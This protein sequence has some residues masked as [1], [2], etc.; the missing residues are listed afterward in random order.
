[1]GTY[2]FS[3][4]GQGADLEELA[5]SLFRGARIAT[6]GVGV[7]DRFDLQR[8]PGGY[9]LRQA[10]RT[11]CGASDLTGAFR[12]M[13]WALTEACLAHLDAY[14]QFHAGAVVCRGGA[15]LLP[16]SPEAGKTSLALALYAAGATVWTDEVALL[17]PH[18]LVAVPFPRDLVVRRGT[19]RALV[20]ALPAPAA[21]WQCTAEHSYL[22]P[23]DLRSR[24]RAQA[25]VVRL[26]FP[27]LAP[28]RCP[29]SRRLGPAEAARRL[30]DQALNGQHWHGAHI[31]ALAR[32]VARCPATEV[33]FSDCRTAARALLARW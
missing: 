3:L 8:G 33:T 26:V 16:G 12:A 20:G 32:L 23:A 27:R 11:I 25:P 10:G 28:G 15:W 17:D 31:T 22:S 4:C 1:V 2:G 21:P 5:A 18:T 7:G 9:V 6:A 14:L 30:L 13:E 24:P 19:T 29:R